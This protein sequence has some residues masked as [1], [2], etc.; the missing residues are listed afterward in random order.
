LCDIG[1]DGRTKSANQPVVQSLIERGFIT[2]SEEPRVR[3]KLTFPAQQTL[4]KRGLG[5]NES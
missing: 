1:T 5:L 3:L 2:L 4:G